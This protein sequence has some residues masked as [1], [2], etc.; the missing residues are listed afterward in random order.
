MDP[1]NSNLAIELSVIGDGTDALSVRC[2]ARNTAGHTLHVF[3]ASRMPYLL[4]ERGALVLLHCAMPPAQDRDLNLIELP[5][6]R[7]LEPNQ[8]LTFAVAL[9]PLR[10]RDHYGEAPP[11][12]PTHGAA[13]VVC[14][15]GY[16]ASPIVPGSMSIY[17]LLGWQRL[18]PSSTVTVRFP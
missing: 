1:M 11:R 7:P 14:L 18:A 17:G 16:G 10:L 15:V 8:T 5:A 4:D 3:D 6:T 13:R 2:V 12:P 9:V